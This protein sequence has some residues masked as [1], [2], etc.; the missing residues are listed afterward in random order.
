M[1]RS[2]RL[3]F[4]IAAYAITIM[5]LLAIVALALRLGSGLPI[6]TSMLAAFFG[7]FM[8][9]TGTRRRMRPCDPT[10]VSIKEELSL[11]KLRAKGPRIQF[12]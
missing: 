3:W 8:A 12:R 5:A 6:I 9:I 2:T 11:R 10:S 4:G 7:V 1:T